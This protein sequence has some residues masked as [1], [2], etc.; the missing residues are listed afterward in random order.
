MAVPGAATALL[1]PPQAATAHPPACSCGRQHAGWAGRQGD[2]AP[3]GRCACSAKCLFLQAGEQE[4]PPSGLTAQEGGNPRR[5]P[6]ISCCWE[7]T[8]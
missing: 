3:L 7:G 4:P 1:A 8:T 5:A 2:Q 6:E